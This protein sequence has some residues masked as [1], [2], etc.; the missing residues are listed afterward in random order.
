MFQVTLTTS[1]C[2][3]KEGYQ[4]LIKSDYILCVQGD[5]LLIYLK[6]NRW[7]IEL[8]LSLFDAVRSTSPLYPTS[9]ASLCILL[10]LLAFLLCFI[11]KLFSKTR[12]QQR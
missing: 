4:P 12:W 2:Q 1:Y 11:F 10:L 5:I 7:G 3:C 6:V 8:I 9:L